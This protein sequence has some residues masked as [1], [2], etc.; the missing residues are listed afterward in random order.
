MMPDGAIRL[1]N[2]RRPALLAMVAA[3][4]LGLAACGEAEK[5]AEAPATPAPTAEAPEPTAEAPATPE[6]ATPAPA[7]VSLPTPEATVDVAALAAPGPFTEM[8]LGSADAK[9]TVIEYASLTC[10]H[11]GAF[12]TSTFKELQTKYI[13]TG[14]IRFI[15]REYPFDAL[16]EAGFMLARCNEQVYFP[17]ISA[18]FTA[19]EKWVRAEKPSEA[20]FQISKQ[21][22][23]TQEKFN[24]CLQDQAVLDKI[25]TVRTKA[26][27]D[28]G[29]NSTPTF[30]IN[31]KKF[32]GNMSIETFSALI[33]AEM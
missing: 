21:A 31:G 16:A 10:G 15:F 22:G 29:V 30:F 33:E 27:D 32:P 9:V 14:K 11:C 12:H 19:Q 3:M 8:V 4:A 5:Q 6:P 20:M 17:M 23:F 1:N 18:L 7:T 2:N 26:T 24:A 13:D 25:R 28:F